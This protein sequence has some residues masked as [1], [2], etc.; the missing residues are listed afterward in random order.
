M[1]FIS[2]ADIPVTLSNHTAMHGI[3]AASKN[4]LQ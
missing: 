2:I 1:R 3:I 4:L